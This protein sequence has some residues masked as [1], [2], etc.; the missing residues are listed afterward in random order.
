MLRVPRAEKQDRA[1]GARDRETGRA[2]SGFRFLRHRA[3]HELAAARVEKSVHRH[4]HADDEEA[5]ARHQVGFVHVPRRTLLLLRWLGLRR[6]GDAV[7]EVAGET[8]RAEADDH[9]RD[10]R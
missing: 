3:G 6:S 7:L 9:Q 1:A 5:G 10:K 2:E 8:R 4:R